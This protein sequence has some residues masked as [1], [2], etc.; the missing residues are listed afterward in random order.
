MLEKFK[1]WWAKPYDDGMSVT[2][3][4]YFFGL[5]IVISVLWALV[6]R[7]IKEAVN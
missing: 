3:W 6:L 7:E 5:I 4:F 1:D 2:G